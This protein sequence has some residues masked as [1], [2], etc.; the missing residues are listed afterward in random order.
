MHRKQTRTSPSLLDS[1]VLRQYAAGCLEVIQPTLTRSDRDPE[2][3]KA[4]GE[5]APRSFC[6][7]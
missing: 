4:M 1:R 3:D 2:R 7:D 6:C 5:A